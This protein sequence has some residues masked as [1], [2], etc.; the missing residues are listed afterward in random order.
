MDM[1][2]VF[3]DIVTVFLKFYLD[4]LSADWRGLSKMCAWP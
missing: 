3:C 1:Q 4:E 2:Y